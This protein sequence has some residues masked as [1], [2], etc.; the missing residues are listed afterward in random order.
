MCPAD[1]GEDRP[2]RAVRGG[3]RYNSQPFVR[4][5]SHATVMGSALLDKRKM[6]RADAG[7][8]ANPAINIKLVS[9]LPVLV[10]LADHAAGLMLVFMMPHMLRLRRRTF[11]H[12]IGS[13]RR[14][15]E[16]E[17]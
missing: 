10:G 13:H 1:L 11:M 7:A 4:L 6:E 14:P 12:A 16:L 17:R 2:L 15:A 5:G 3:R 9:A 8:M